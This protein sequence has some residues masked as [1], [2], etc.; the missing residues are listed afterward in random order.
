MSGRVL[1]WDPRRD[2]PEIER[3]TDVRLHRW[4]AGRTTRQRIANP[5]Q[6]VLGRFLRDL[7]VPMHLHRGHAIQ[8]GG[9]Q[10]D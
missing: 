4:R 7:Q 6:Q 5:S 10:I 8:T 1:S 3:E 2:K 9:H